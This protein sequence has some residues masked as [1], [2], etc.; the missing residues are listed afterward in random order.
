MS[1]H[2]PKKDPSDLAVVTEVIRP[3]AVVPEE[4]A[5]SIL[6]AL[7]LNGVQSGGLWQAEASRW[8]RYDRPWAGPH[9]PGSAGLV[10]SLQ[11]AFGTPTKYE[12]TIYRVTITLHGSQLGWTVQSL[13][14]EALGLGGLTLAQC[15]RAALTDPPKPF[16]G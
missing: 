4:E 13:S 15:P 16:R 8:S 6:V 7:S 1:P 12:I 5:Q 14:D 10:G 9:D 11:I 2:V 3:A